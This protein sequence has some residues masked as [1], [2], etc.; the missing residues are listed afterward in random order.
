MQKRRKI[1]IFD[2][3]KLDRLADYVY[4]IV[5]NQ[6]GIDI[7]DLFSHGEKKFIVKII[8][9]DLSYIKNNYQTIDSKNMIVCFFL[10]TVF[11]TSIEI[12]DFLIDCFRIDV[13]SVPQKTQN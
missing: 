7:L 5:S 10:A 11:S 9:N 6:T 12:I 13:Q 3:N 4:E 2:D 1:D 8:Q